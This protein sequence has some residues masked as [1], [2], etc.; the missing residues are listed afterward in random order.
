MTKPRITPIA[1]HVNNGDALDDTA[2]LPGN[3]VQVPTVVLQCP[4]W[5]HGEKIMWAVIA[6]HCIDNDHC[7]PSNL[8]LALITGLQPRRVRGVI[9]S[10][11]HKH[12]LRI[13]PQTINQKRRLYPLIPATPGKKMPGGGQQIAT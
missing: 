10:L 12:G 7:W 3:F 9:S 2:T 6:A 11:E 13:E 8:R 1:P 5:T 4:D